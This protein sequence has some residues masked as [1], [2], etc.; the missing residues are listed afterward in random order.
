MFLSEIT[1]NQGERELENAKV[2]FSKAGHI[3]NPNPSLGGK[4]CQTQSEAA[5]SSQDQSWSKAPREGTLRVRAVG[6]PAEQT[7]SRDS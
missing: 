1:Q 6:R 7:S 4:G 2:L 5:R 3:C